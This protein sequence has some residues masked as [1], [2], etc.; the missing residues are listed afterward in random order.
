LSEIKNKKAKILL[1]LYMAP[2]CAM[3]Y[4]CSNALFRDAWFDESLTILNFTLQPG[5]WKI[6]NSYVIPN[7]HI[8]YTIVL[9]YWV[10]LYSLVGNVATYAYR[11]PSF[12]S[13]FGV[14]ALICFCWRKRVGTPGALAAALALSC[15]MP[16]MIYS[17]AIRGYMLSFL[18]LVVALEFA[19][20]LRRGG[21]WLSALGYLIFSFLAVLTIPSNII[22][23]G[24]IF[25]LIVS[26]RRG[27]KLLSMR[28]CFL[29]AAPIMA[30]LIAY[31]PIWQN[32]RKIL[33][34]RE[35]WSGSGDVIASVYFAVVFGLLPLLIM[36]IAGLAARLSSGR[37][38]YFKLGCRGLIFVMPLPFIFMRDPAPFPRVFFALWC[39]W[40]Y[41]AA[42]GAAD[43]I[44]LLRGRFKLCHKNMYVIYAILA[45]VIFGWGVIQRQ[46]VDYVSDDMLAIRQTDDYFSPYYMRE[47]FKPLKTVNKVKEIC[48]DNKI[49]VYIS[50]DADPWSIIFY[51]RMQGMDPM[52]FA[53]DNPKFKIEVMPPIALAILH[54]EDDI[55]QL[56]DKYRVQNIELV[57]DQGF[58][59]IYLIRTAS[60]GI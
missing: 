28:N 8:F 27:Q 9:K 45:G 38:D 12:L 3:L 4:F 26:D 53:F 54:D 22:G 19:F 7:N 31:L 43:F 55:R 60:S 50:F 20:I 48:Q 14:L 30:L 32:V 36:S 40:L 23:L 16:F 59:K 39:V 29:G 37:I 46:T 44:A 17:T 10:E 35:G 57:S 41:L 49:P 25:L 33:A 51:A 42:L 21:L 1:A 15:A 56:R 5:P 52:Q 47:S 13:G 2:V 58:Q 34:L 18:L 24:A 11:M 6:Y